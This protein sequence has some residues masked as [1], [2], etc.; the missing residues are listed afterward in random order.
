MAGRVPDRAALRTADANRPPGGR[1][2]PQP[3]GRGASVIALQR[4]IGNRAT[5]AL[6]ARAPS[7]VLQEGS[8]PS[9]EVAKLQLH[10]NQIDS[11]QTALFP[12]EIFGPETA[13]AVREFQ[14]SHPPLEVD[15]RA[16]PQTLP[17]IDAARMEPQDQTVMA[18]KLFDLGA[19][20][21]DRG[22]YG[23]AYGYFMASHKRAPDRPAIV[24]SA[25][26]ALRREGG[27]RAEA[28]ALYK[29]Y[30]SSDS[31]T[32]AQDARTALAELETHATG[33]ADADL[34]QAKADFDKGAAD[35]DRGDYAHA[36]D[37]FQKAGELEPGHPALLFSEAQALR[38][39]GGR[40]DEAIALFQAY[41]DSGETKRAADARAAIDELR[42]TPSGDA[43]ADVAAAKASFAQGAAA[44]DAKKYGVAADRFAKADDL[45]P[46]RPGLLY[47]EAVSLMHMGGHTDEAIDLFRRYIAAGGTRKQAA[48]YVEVLT[49]EG[50]DH[51]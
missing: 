30:L 20:S 21:Y 18:R 41:L 31:P 46:G 38:H 12:D 15:G 1:A 22:R 2:R 34:A 28:I 24:F 49:A 39:L 43:E 26:Q 8:P 27:H 47:S 9:L 50:A 4:A 32:R 6:V 13:K 10:L 16:G 40:R 7:P 29:E 23:D 33:D 48:F 25:A 42:G 37:E 17:A 19:K 36:Y 45:A 44:Y 11:V 3:A 14:R 51:Y 5:A 35:Y